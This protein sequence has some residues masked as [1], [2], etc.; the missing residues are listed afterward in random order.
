MALVPIN[1]VKYIQMIEESTG[2]IVRLKTYLPIPNGEI[3]YGFISST[4]PDGFINVSNITE[5]NAVWYRFAD[6]SL[7]HF[8]LKIYL[9]AGDYIQ[10][11]LYNDDLFVSNLSASSTT[12]F[13]LTVNDIK[14]G[15]IG[16]MLVNDKHY[17]CGT[18][19]KLQQGILS[20]I[21]YPFENLPE[22]M[23]LEKWFGDRKLIEIGYPGIPSNGGGGGGS[24]TTP[25]DP[26]KPPTETPDIGELY[27]TRLCRAYVLNSENLIKF[28]KVHTFIYSRRK[29]TKGDLMP[30]QVDPAIKSE[31]NKRREK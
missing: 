17:I 18:I 23:A 31:R 25:H 27:A 10:C 11:H 20:G 3:R 1:Q 19:K 30:N 2:K 13:I 16:I 8:R 9:E 15:G 4:V 6:P 14:Y 29:G 26:I 12:G 22:D 28:A 24:F 7:Y 21:V 5:G